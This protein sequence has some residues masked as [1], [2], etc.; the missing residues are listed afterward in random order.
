M[1]SSFIFDISED[2]CGLGPGEPDPGFHK[3]NEGFVGKISLFWN[4]SME[5]DAPILPLVIHIAAL[6]GAP[7][8]RFKTVKKIMCRFTKSPSMK[9]IG[10]CAFLQSRFF[11]GPGSA[12]PEKAGMVH[13]RHVKEKPEIRVRKRGQNQKKRVIRISLRR[14]EGYGARH[15]FCYSSPPRFSPPGPIMIPAFLMR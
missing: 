5:D 12:P 8:C 10:L 3:K 7:P 13:V 9:R 2:C 1:Y 11:P 15:L 14:P 6:E 4:Y